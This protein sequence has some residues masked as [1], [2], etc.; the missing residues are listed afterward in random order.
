MKTYKWDD[1]RELY[2]VSNKYWKTGDVDLVSRR[3]EVAQDVDGKYWVEIS[4]LALFV[5]RLHKPFNVLVEELKILGFEAK[6]QTKVGNDDAK[7]H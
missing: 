5:A 2:R 1:L 3:N 6:E 7:I 4:D